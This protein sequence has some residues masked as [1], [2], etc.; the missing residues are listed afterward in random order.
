MSDNEIFSHHR[1]IHP[2]MS[3]GQAKEVYRTWLKFKHLG[4]AKVVKQRA[5]AIEKDRQLRERLF[6]VEAGSVEE[7]QDR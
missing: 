7:G 6:G 4:A 5:E 1:Q 3:M 2:H